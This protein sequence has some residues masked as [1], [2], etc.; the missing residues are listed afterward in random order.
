MERMVTMIHHFDPQT[1]I[2]IWHRLCAGEDVK[3]PREPWQ[4]DLDDQIAEWAQD[5]DAFFADLATS[6]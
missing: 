5:L 3:F 4:D 6:N 1:R 2:D